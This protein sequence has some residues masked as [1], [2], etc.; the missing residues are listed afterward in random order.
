MTDGDRGFGST[1]EPAAPPAA[2]ASLAQCAQ[3]ETAA[4]GACR[5]CGDYFCEACAGEP[6]NRGLCHRCD[7]LV[8]SIPWEHE[9]AELGALRAWLRTLHRLFIA[10]GDVA[11]RLPIQGSLRAPA[12]FAAIACGAYVVLAILVLGTTE[13]IRTSLAIARFGAENVTWRL[14]LISFPHIVVPI[15]FTTPASVF[16]APLALTA[17][18]RLV[19]A[20][21]SLRASARTTLYAAGYFVLM[22]LP[23]GGIAAVLLFP[24]FLYRMLEARTELPRVRR[25]LAVAFLL[26]ALLLIRGAIHAIYP[27]TLQPLVS[28]GVDHIFDVIDSSSASD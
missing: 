18:T 3:H 6:P 25:A 27:L 23:L 16:L 15:F 20:P 11:R 14:A 5:R 12:V 19:G 24:V 21:L 4:A 9:R 8:G 1:T 17:A 26:V 10:P 22:G 7:R 28:A 2:G 13:W